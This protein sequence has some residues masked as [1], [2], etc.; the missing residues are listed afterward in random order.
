MKKIILISGQAQHGK[1]STAQ[2]LKEKFEE[3]GNRVIILPFAKYIKQILK[4][5]YGWDGVDKSDMWR[6]KLQWLGTEKIRMEMKRPNFHVDRI[7][8]DIK[9]VEDDFDYI[10]IDDCR[11][12]NEAYITK[13]NFPGKVYHIKVDRLGFESPLTEEQRNHP[14]ER[15]MD[16]YV[17]YDNL[18]YAE[19]G[20]DN[21]KREVLIYCEELLNEDLY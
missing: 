9:I 1:T 3:K 18:I 12:I 16:G 6:E 11:F 4:D 15:G 7:C 14:S 19:N 21:L 10:I 8:D 20:L 17:D 13:G 5:F 2:I